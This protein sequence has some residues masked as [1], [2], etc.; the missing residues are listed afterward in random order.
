MRFSV[1]FQLGALVALGAPALGAPTPAQDPA[2]ND[3]AALAARGVE[4]PSVLEA[5]KDPGL[6][7]LPKKPK[8]KPT[9]APRPN[10][11]PPAR[12][13]G[14]AEQLRRIHPGFGQGN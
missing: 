10:P 12:G 6:N 11:P 13:A 4:E 5:R 7:A 8:K 1:L 3:L 14:R 9:P 2:T